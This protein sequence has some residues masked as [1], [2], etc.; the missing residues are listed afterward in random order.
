MQILGSNSMEQN[1]EEANVGTV[2]HEI[3]FLL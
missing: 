3:F 2:T 1:P